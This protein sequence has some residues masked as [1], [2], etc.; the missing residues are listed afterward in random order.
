MPSVALLEGEQ[1][2]SLRSRCL[3]HPA[4]AVLLTRYYRD[5]LSFCL[6][7][8]RDRDA[9]ADLAQESVTRVLAMQRAGQAILEPGALLRQV[10]LRAKIDLDRR[11]QVRQHDALEELDEFSQPS[12]A[13][14]LQPE[15]VYASSRA[16]AAYLETIEQ[17]PPRCREAFSLYVFDD[18]SNREIAERMGVS[19][20]MVNQ[21]I[22]RGKLA[23]A[24]CREALERDA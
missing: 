4:R 3:A 11:A 8:T 7:K 16:V 15:Q 23:C 13:P 10:A 19:L 24:A 6:R 17:L 9:A 12:S 20:S 21:Y 22:S 1:T 2:L 14:H 5:L 18:L